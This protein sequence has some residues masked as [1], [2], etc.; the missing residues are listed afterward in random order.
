[1]V[2]TVFK[3][4]NWEEKKKSIG[5]KTASIKILPSQCAEYTFTILNTQLK[6]KPSVHY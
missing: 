5:K 1:M 6:I 4:E 2:K 3:V